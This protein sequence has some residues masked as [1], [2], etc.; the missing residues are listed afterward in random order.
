[1]AK[2]SCPTLQGVS[3][4]GVWRRRRKGLGDIGRYDLVC[5]GA[6]SHTRTVCRVPP[7]T[8][9]KGPLHQTCPANK[10]D[11]VRSIKCTPYSEGAKAFTARRFRVPESAQGL[12]ER[13]KSRKRRTGLKAEID[14]ACGNLTGMAKVDCVRQVFARWTKAN[15]KARA[16]AA[17]VPAVVEQPPAPKRKRSRTRREK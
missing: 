7:G 11:V 1:M 6:S 8:L 17:E 16:A 12:F 3:L 10:L 9:P 14:A 5:A 15:A 13:I 2:C 4:E